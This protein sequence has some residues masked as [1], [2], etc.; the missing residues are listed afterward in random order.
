MALPASRDMRIRTGDVVIAA[1]DTIQAQ[2]FNLSADGGK[3]DIAG[4][5]DAN[6]KKWWQ[7]CN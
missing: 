4:T 1:G 7:D 6:G 5:I 3:I 2:E